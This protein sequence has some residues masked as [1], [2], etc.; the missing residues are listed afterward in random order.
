GNE[1]E[2]NLKDTISMQRRE[3]FPFLDAL[4]G[5]SFIGIFILHASQPMWDNSPI[6]KF[7]HHFR[8]S[9][10]FSIDVFFILSSFLLTYLGLREF[11]KHGRFSFK[12]YFLR[13]ALRIWPLYYLIMVLSFL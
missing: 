11:E 10:S 1:R 6:D 3:Y 8:F 2:T 5:L 7:L 4:R 9:L 13:R 12:N